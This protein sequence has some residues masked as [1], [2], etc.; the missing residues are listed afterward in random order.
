LDKPVRKIT[1]NFGKKNTGFFPSKKNGRSIAYESLLERDYMYL[2]EYDKEVISF[3]EQPVTLEYNYLD[4]K[5][6]YT[7]DLKVVRKVNTEIVEIKPKSILLQ[8]LNDAKKKAKFDV[9][10]YYCVE[11]GYKFKI[12]TDEDIHNGCILTNIKY[13]FRYSLIYVPPSDELKIKNELAL[14]E[15]DIET[16]LNRLNPLDNYNQFKVYIYSLIFEGV[17]RID[18]KQ[19][20][21]DKSIIKL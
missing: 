13:L 1:N 12:V 16:L 20:L 19:P 10:N 4:R 7:P 6:T 18:L 14:G 8:F 2:L 11:N 5:R 9:A 15:L 3:T 21:T 17:I